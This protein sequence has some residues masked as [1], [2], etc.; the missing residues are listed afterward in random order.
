MDTM[1]NESDPKDTARGALS[2]LMDAELAPASLAMALSHWRDDSETRATWHA[3]HLIGDVMRST[4]LAHPPARDEDFLRGLRTRLASEPVP[5][6]P[7]ALGS[8]P[9]DGADARAALRSDPA[10]AANG[11][12]WMAPVAVAAGFVA[13]AALLVVT[14]VVGVNPNDGSQ[15]A[16]NAGVTPNALAGAEP[17]RP[18]ALDPYLEAH[19]S[20]GNGVAASGGADHRVRIVFETQ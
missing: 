2:S 14:R 17:V 4:D 8:S 3:Y 20:L 19:R 9:A 12:W 11:R 18:N 10:V 6:A 15:M 7:M 5:L 16:A 1:S 13:V